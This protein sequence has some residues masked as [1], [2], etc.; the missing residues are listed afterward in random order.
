MGLQGFAPKLVGFNAKA[1]RGSSRNQSGGTP[2]V[3]VKVWVM[4]SQTSSL[5]T[6]VP[7]AFLNRFGTSITGVWSGFDRRRLRGTLRPLFQA[8]HRPR[9]AAASRCRHPPVAVAAGAWPL[10]QSQRHP[11]L[12]R[13]RGRTQNHHRAAGGAPGGCRTTHGTCGVKKSSQKETM[14]SD[15]AVKL[16]LWPF[17]AARTAIGTRASARFSVNLQG[18]VE[19]A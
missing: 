14:S 4:K 17:L 12:R 1:W 10:A 3:R 7:P 9:R 18:D 13:D 19:A 2:G 11:S 5:V 16:K 6:G 15:R 8:R